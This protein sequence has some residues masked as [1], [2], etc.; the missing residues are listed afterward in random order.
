ML[1]PR[2]VSYPFTVSSEGGT[3]GFQAQR[4]KKYKLSS[5]TF[6]RFDSFTLE[7]WDC[8]FLFGISVILFFVDTSVFVSKKTVFQ[9]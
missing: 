7:S 5:R 2:I 8:D 6:F 9:H 4:L 1:N 3:V